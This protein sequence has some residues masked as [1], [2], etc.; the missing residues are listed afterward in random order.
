[1]DGWTR[2]D[3]LATILE[4]H[5]RGMHAPQAMVLALFFLFV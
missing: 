2:L 3:R 5:S 4:Y 1:M